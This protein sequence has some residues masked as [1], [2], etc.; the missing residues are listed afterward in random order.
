M[1]HSVAVFTWSQSSVTTMKKTVG[2]RNEYQRLWNHL[3][4][5]RVDRVRT[6]LPCFN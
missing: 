6:C 1:S 2:H 3:I 4:L 5:C